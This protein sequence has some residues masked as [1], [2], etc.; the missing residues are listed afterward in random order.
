MRASERHAA[1]PRPA[2]S[3]T[4]YHDGV[5]VERETETDQL[6]MALEDAAT[7]RGTVVVVSGEAGTGK[8]ALIEEFVRSERERARVLWGA[9]DDLVT[10][11]PLG[12]LRDMAR[13]AGG[14]LAEAL[15]AEADPGEVMS[16]FLAE[17]ERSGPPTVVVFEDAHWA[18]QASLDVLRFVGRRLERTRAMLIVTV[19]DEDPH[20]SVHAALGSIPASLIR[21][22]ELRPLS[23]EGI[24]L[25]ATGQDWSVDDLLTLTDGNPFFVT[26]LIHAPVASVPRSIRDA[27]MARLDG[28]S[29][30]ARDLA[31]LAAV[32]PARV[33]ISLLEALRTDVDRLL[34]ESERAAL[35]QVDPQHAWYRHELS[36]QAVEA[37]LTKARRRELNREVLRLLESLGADPARLVHHAEQAGDRDAVARWALQAGQEA[38]RAGAHRE[39]LVHYQR[40]VDA[41]DRI[42]AKQRAEAVEQLAT[43]AYFAD[44]AEVAVAA[45]ER[46]LELRRA[47]G[48]LEAIGRTARLLSRLYWFQGQRN[49]AEAMA[50][51]TVDTLERLPPGSDLA[52]AYSNRSQLAML[53]GQDDEAVAWGTKAIELARSLEAPEPLVHALNNVGSARWHSGDRAPG[54]ELL[55]QSLDL[56]RQ[57]GL[58]EHASRAYI[59]LAWQHLENH[60][61]EAASRLLEEGLAYSKDHEII[62]LETYLMGTRARL[63]LETGDWAGAQEDAAAALGRPEDLRISVIPSLLVLGRLQVRRGD[64]AAESTLDRTW[65]QALASGE[66]TRIGPAAAT[67]AEWAWLE[68]D[69]DRAREELMLAYELAARAGTDW[70]RGEIA[71]WCW[72]LGLSDGAPEGIA[73]PYRLHLE[74][75][76]GEAASLW[77]EIGCPYERADALADTDDPGAKEEALDLF[78]ALGATARATRL[79]HELGARIRGSRMLVSVLFTDLVDSTRRATELG[80]RRWR[81]LLDAHDAAVRDSVVHHGGQVVQSTGDGVLAT[82]E[83]PSSAI[84]AAFDLGRRIAAL[85]LEVRAGV[86]TGEIERRGDDIGGI[87]V[88]IGAR[89]AA[90]AEGGEVLVSETTA[91]LAAGSGFHFAD[92][93]T[94]RL[95]GVP[96]EWRV[97]SAR[98]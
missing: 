62:G 58:H 46:A 84:E 43:E 78:E 36:R 8:T 81:A 73:A 87:G 49:R 16:A 12:P 83:L 70:Q 26:E 71:F 57:H 91:V 88:H 94:H 23:R 50:E 35:L 31:E 90:L 82:F 1:S 61:Y 64:A 27:V 54:E 69:P 96:G 72:R 44:R 42:P 85:G 3:G 10:P 11:R 19:R 45:G 52:M 76:P 92:G 38:A 77:E 15:D 17:L 56:A 48:N 63:R 2:G 95:K 14:R 33:E 55:R 98:R 18:D 68:G 30:E 40:V 97:L 28:L 59:N 41:L 93:G 74:G 22:L 4:A 32:V 24:E 75:R 89:I 80:D 65:Q 20:G 60:H 86:H 51:L 9:S 67:M 6:R 7:G 79:R 5:L 37:S 47:E 34:G 29:D 53:A 66:V 21:R 25:L 39:A 13:L